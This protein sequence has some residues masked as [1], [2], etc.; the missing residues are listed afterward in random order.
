MH[1]LSRGYSRYSFQYKHRVTGHFVPKSFRTQV[2]LYP[3]FGHFESSNNH[4]VPRSFRTNFGHFVPS[5]TGYEMTFESKSFRTQVISY[6]LW[7]FRT[8]VI[9]YL[10]YFVN[11][12]GHFVPSSTGYEMT[13]I[14]EHTSVRF[15]H[16][17]ILHG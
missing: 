5:S 10:G 7:S 9:S 4:F 17:V 2:N 1:W 11:R 3:L 14:L 12:Y 16:R 8:Y 15:I 13:F 6:L